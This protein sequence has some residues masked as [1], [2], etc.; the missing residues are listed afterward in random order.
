MKEFTLQQQCP[1][2]DVALKRAE[3]SLQEFDE[4]SSSLS[5]PCSLDHASCRCP[6]LLEYLP[7]ELDLSFAKSE[8][9]GWILQNP[10]HAMHLASQ[11]DPTW[12]QSLEESPLLY[13]DEQ[14][15]LLASTT[16]GIPKTW[17]PSIMNR[18]ALQRGATF[19]N[20][21]F[22]ELANRPAPDATMDT[23][24]LTKTPAQEPTATPDDAATSSV[25]IEKQPEQTL[26]SSDERFKAILANEEHI[27]G[28]QS[29]LLASRALKN[30]HG[31]RNG[32]CKKGGE[33]VGAR[34][35][36]L[37]TLPDTINPVKPSNSLG[38]FAA[39]D[40]QATQFIDD[41]LLNQ[42]WTPPGRLFTQNDER[43][44]N[45]KL[46]QAQTKVAV[47]LE[48]YKGARQGYYRNVCV[49]EQN[50]AA[51]QNK[52]FFHLDI[53]AGDNAKQSNCHQCQRYCGDDLMHCLDCAFVGCYV[54]VD[55]KVVSEH[56]MEHM[57][58]ENHNFAVTG[59]SCAKIFCF[60]C[61]DFVTH[62]V[63][64]Q[65][66]E[67][68]DLI[69][70]FPWMGWKDHHLQRSFD[71]LRF[72]HVSEHRIVWRGMA[73]TY[74][75]LVP[76]EHIESAR[77]CRWRQC[78]FHGVAV[79][80]FG[81]ANNKVLAFARHQRDKDLLHRCKLPAPVG[82][83]NLGNSC[84]M[85]AILQ[86]LLH[87][88]PLQ[89]Y[90]LEDVGH[91]HLSC[92]MY[93]KLL[94]KKAIKSSCLA[95]ELDKLFLA[96]FE[97]SNGVEAR[98]LLQAEQLQPHEVTPLVSGF[99]AKDFERVKGEPLIT[100]DLLTVAWKCMT[101]IAGYE[102]RDAHEFLHSFLECLGK[103]M[104]LYRVRVHNTINMPQPN[105]ASVSPFVA[106]NQD[107]MKN[108]FEG[109]LR[110]VLV[111]QK[112]GNKRIQTEPF[113][114]LSL[115]LSKE[116]H[117]GSYGELNASGSHGISV[118]QCLKHF[119]LPE[120]LADPVDC[121]SC[122]A[123]TP[124]TRQHVVSRLPKILVLHLKRFDFA[125]NRKIEEYVSFPAHG[126]NMGPYLPHWCE[127]PRVPELE[128]D[129]HFSIADAGL[130]PRIIYNL[131]STVNHFGN[132]QSGHYYANVKV[133]E[134][135]Y[136][137]NDAHVSLASESEVVAQPAYMLFYALDMLKI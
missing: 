67:R 95:C 38:E 62:P 82:M 8:T 73:A 76:L 15:R 59:G 80:T 127:I 104:R 31:T 13:G 48:H 5:Q 125:E 20:G 83:W 88:S 92:I 105:N 63:F 60:K 87:S 1:P 40:Q 34:E 19:D 7:H 130:E 45:T 97:N 136:H 35:T 16:E 49:Q 25:V 3:A 58:V 43:A 77:L 74:P 99:Q 111:C 122:G 91:H 100:S 22:T 23:P 89:R 56:M 75:Q 55:D 123:Q 103:H 137:C 27:R 11:L 47:W 132:L 118:E 50:R 81:A 110:A 109:N 121:P 9:R 115:P 120:S 32:H 102:Q 39:N 131:Q 42:L 37:S 133:N 94:E 30:P 124:T 79:G 17:H 6:H 85:T 84:Y 21:M 54:S 66:R 78:L 46:L 28:I 116:I 18:Q 107:Y 2:A 129:D 44:W 10:V 119:T 101:H 96:Y 108:L 112:C 126:L 114:S 68:I 12:L 14:E 93:R 128:S 41:N 53:D 70:N 51:A 113:M 86:C 134:T 117:K 64:T 4:R 135:W 61:G 36:D 69:N 24:I 90:F 71:A 57:V 98:S 33:S 26:S 106:A 72:M 52:S 65:E 29:T